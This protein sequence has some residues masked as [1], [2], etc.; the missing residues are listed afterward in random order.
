MVL[1]LHKFC[2][3]LDICAEPRKVFSLDGFAEPLWLLT[4]G[5]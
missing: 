4:V 3:L 5:G 1:P 2:L